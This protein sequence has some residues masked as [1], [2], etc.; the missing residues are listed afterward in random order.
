LAHVFKVSLLVILRRLLDVG[1]IDQDT[2]WQAYYVEAERILSYERG[3]GSGGDFYRTLAART[4]KLFARAV[5]SSA[6]EG[7]TLF[8]DAFRMLGIRKTATFYEAARE[9]GVML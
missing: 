6:L 5:I 9:L 3:G 7:Q 1:A 4:G 8:R 2:Y